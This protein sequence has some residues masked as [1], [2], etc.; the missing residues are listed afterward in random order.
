M[1]EKKQPTHE[2]IDLVYTEEEGN[3]AYQGSQ[4]EC[5]N[6]VDEQCMGGSAHFTYEVK[7][8]IRK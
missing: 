2:V 4:H 5:L 8:I 7:P 3:V 6:W 1:E